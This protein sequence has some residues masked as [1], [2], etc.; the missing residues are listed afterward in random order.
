M[1]F[2]VI[3]L[4]VLLAGACVADRSPPR[5]KS[6]EPSSAN[7]ARVTLDPPQLPVIPG[8]R[9]RGVCFVAGHDPVGPAAFEDLHEHGVTWISQTPFGWQDKA[10]DPTFRIVTEGRVYWGERDS[11]LT[12]TARMARAKGIR[13]LLKPHL[14]LRD[15]S[16][17]QWVGSIAM[18]NEADWAAWFAR[19]E[20]FI[21]HY[22]RLAERLGM[23]GFSVGTELEGTSGR[24]GDW[25]RIIAA[26]RA[27][28]H[29]RLTYAANWSEF[30]RIEFWDD[31]DWIGVQAYFPLT[32]K[33]EASVDELVAGWAPHV[34]RIEAVQKRFARPVL[35]TEIGYK[36]AD[37]A[38]VE[39][40][41]WTTTDR[42]NPDEQARAYE[43][44]FRV[45]WNEPWCAGMYWWKWFPDGHHEAG[46]RDRYFTP[47]DKPAAAVMRR[48]Y[49]GDAGSG[50]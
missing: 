23:E 6:P 14:W 47:Q 5:S 46:G 7:A 8:A 27:V 21:V 40:W 25:R 16:D 9:H 37:R 10:D 48:W 31:L 33:A 45:F 12:E 36:A 13:T 43:A 41:I 1:T 34:A 18:K 44:A 35:L 39:P 42:Y 2:A 50:G 3:G 30:E 17:G 24:T 28:Y 4:V 49:R 15:R 38:T 19:Y 29:G 26:V 32:D 22:A 11:G 20:E